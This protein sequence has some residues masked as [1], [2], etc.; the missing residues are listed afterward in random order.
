MAGA[1]GTFCRSRIIHSEE[2][3]GRKPRNRYD[4]HDHATHREVFVG[5]GNQFHI[6]V[7]TM[8]GRV[9]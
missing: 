2:Q 8:V 1:T 4:F 9:P 3:S 5:P 7:T 6:I